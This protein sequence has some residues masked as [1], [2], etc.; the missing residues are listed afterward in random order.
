MTTRF[1]RPVAALASALAVVLAVTMQAQPT[2]AAKPDPFAP[3]KAP[4]MP[5]VEVRKVHTKPAAR[6]AQK[7]AGDRRSPKWPSA[8]SADVTVGDTKA[9]IRF[10]Q[11]SGDGSATANARLAAAK[12]SKMRVDVLDQAASQRAAVDGVLF[13]VRRADGRTGRAEVG[14][15]VDYKAFANAYGADWSTRL[16]LVKLPECALTDPELVRCRG[17]AVPGT[18]DTVA[19]AV[20]ADVAVESAQLMAVTAAPSGAAGSYSA[21]KLSPSGVWSAG[22]S[23]GDFSW[24]FPMRVPP[25][26]GGPSPSV[27]L[28]YSAQSVDGRM[29]ASNNQPSEVGEGFELSTGGFI[30]RRYKPCSADKK[31][32]NNTS[33][34]HKISADMCWVTDNAT[35]SL[36]G[37][38]GELIQDADNE[39]LWHLRN[40]DGS[41]IERRFG[42]DNG[43]HDG[44]WWVVTT[45]TGTQ[46]WFGRNKLPGWSAGDDNTNATWTAPIFSNHS[47]EPCYKPEFSASSCTTPWR[48]NLSYVVDPHGNSMSYWYKADTNNYY[49]LGLGKV[50]TY[51]RGGYLDHVSYG[52]RVLPNLETGTDTIFSGHATARVDFDYGDRCLSDCGTKDAVKWPDT[53][54]DLSC[55]SD[56]E[57]DPLAPTFWSTHRLTT[58]TTSVYEQTTG[59][60]RDVEQWGLTH[61]YPDPE[62]GTRAG[63]WLEKVS[64]T[65]LVGTP[66]KLPDVTFTGYPKPNRI[67]GVDH[68]PAM[69]WHRLTDINTETGSILH[70]DYLDSDCVKGSKVPTVPENNKLRCYPVRWT[71]SGHDDELVDYFAKYVVNSVTE[72]DRTGGSPRVLYQYRY[73]GDP[74]WHYSDDDGLIDKDAKTW[75][76]WRGYQKVGVLTGDPGEQTYRETTYFRGMNGDHLPNGTRSATVPDSQGGSVPDDEAFAGVTRETRTL[77]GV[78]GAEVSGELNEPWKSEPT[79]SRTINKVTT[80]ARR[81]GTAAT[82]TR[83]TLDH[84]PWVRTTT[85]KH[86]FDGYGQVVKTEDLGDAAVPGDEQCVKTTYEPRNTKAW[87]LSMPHRTQTFAV[88]CV[89]ADAGGLTEDQVIGDGRTYYDDQNY[90]VAPKKGDVT[91]VEQMDAYNNGSPSY[92]LVSRSAFDDLGRVTNSWDVLGNETKTAYTPATTG[93]VTQTV[94]TNP[95]GWTTKSFVEPA[96][97]LSTATVDVNQLRTSLEYDG[98]G[99]LTKVWKPG[100]TPGTGTPDIEYSYL[101]RTDGVNAVTT[102]HVNAKGGVTK[103]YT[104]YDGLLRTRQTQTASPSGGR[105]LSDTF[106]D[107]AGRQVLSYGAYYDKTGSPGTELVKPLTQQDVPNQTSVEYDAAGRQIAS[108]FQPKGVE[109]WRT[110]TSYGGDHVDVSPPAGATAS[111]TWTDARGRTIQVRQY[112]TRTPSG[113]D[114]DKTDYKY[115]SKGLLASVTG[116]DGSQWA[117]S[118]DLL[119][120]RTSSIDPDSG[121]TTTKYDT[122]GRVTSTTDGNGQVLISAYDK[123][124]RRVAL[125]KSSV[126]SNNQVAQWDY[127][128][129]TFADGVTPVL[130]QVFQSIRIDS[131]RWYIKG[132]TQYDEN[133]RPKV[134]KVTI[135]TGETGLGGSYT[136]TNGYNADGSLAAMSYPA[137]ADLNAE[138]IKYRYTD[139]DQPLDMTTLY[140]NG[141]ESSIVSDSQ[142]DALA[143]ATQYTLYTGKFSGT[144]SRAYVSLE[145]DATTGRLNKISVH[146]DGKNPNTVTDQKYTYDD[147]GNV[148]KIADKPAGGSFTDIQCFTYDRHRRLQDAWT[149]ASDDCI[150]APTN[151]TLGGPAP[152]WQSYSYNAA[153]ARTGLVDHATA[154]GD[155]STTY[156]FADTT[157]AVPTTGQPHVLRSTSTVDSTGTRSATYTYDKAGNTKT[158]PGPNGTQTL[159]WDAENRLQSVTDTSGSNSYLYDADG[160]RLISRDKNGR[161]LYLP[162]QEVRYNNSSATQSCTRYYSFAGSTLAQRTSKGLTW[163]ASDHHGTQ[164]VSIDSVT[165]TETVRRQTP[166]GASRGPNVTWANTKGFVGGTEDPTGLIHIGA[167]EYD[168]ALGRFISVDPVMDS[169][170]PQ[171]MNGYAYA[172]NN[173][174]VNADPSG[175]MY[176][177]ES[178]GGSTVTETPPSTSSTQEEEPPSQPSGQAQAAPQTQSPPKKEPCGWLCKAGNWVDDHKAE[179]A[180][181]AA[182][183]VVGIGCGMAIG[184]TGVGAVAC[185]AAAG[186]VAGAVEYSVNTAVEHEGNWSLGG[187]TKAAVGGAIVG[188]VTGGLFSVGGAGIKA[189]VS[190]MLSGTGAKAAVNAG[191]SAAKKEAGNIVSGLT[192]GGFRNSASKA[193]AGAADG[194]PAAGKRNYAKDKG[195]LRPLTGPYR[196]DGQKV[197]HGH[198]GWDSADGY[199]TVPEGTSVAFYSGHGTEINRFKTLMVGG[200]TRMGPVDVKGP[201][202]RIP[203]YALYPLEVGDSYREGMTLVFE[204]TLLSNLL[205]E[206][207]GTVHW[208]ACRSVSG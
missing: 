159:V 151:A 62:D 49:S 174:I 141:I 41:R 81:T 189:G 79:A 112:P 127:D 192:R 88:D 9:P 27:E 166:F 119:G 183:A 21:T 153:G 60:F 80:H 25:G 56:T 24:S 208:A 32:G 205:E 65:G 176:P 51:T 38:G 26:I 87:I 137:T 194:M 158:R 104:L 17:I 67:D 54:W 196:P 149:P 76:Q 44:E 199:I 96:W 132:V 117:Y 202:S 136:Y 169:S 101:I 142:Y 8:A 64:H 154:K 30:E 114:Y 14:V 160:N 90:G 92:A 95:L 170:N 39:N 2:W 207:Q 146:R 140:G 52:T 13:R 103:S 179:I 143:H 105:I 201:G 71:P 16:Q 73:I 134:S 204:R 63:L 18:N 5:A 70:V 182:G 47:G 35:M 29:V 74:A 173:P 72:T 188:G 57:C 53:P 116:P 171:S 165:Q 40:D 89:K 94:D 55:T 1:S 177:M 91:K 195:Q 83:T 185:G 23:S 108:V 168:S 85:T 77:L 75:N 131:G 123:L 124:S 102:S 45:T 178:G 135:P 33:D 191:T 133:Y 200:D 110:T 99:R 20:S 180:G 46:Y 19:Q 37:A 34:L 128:Q 10:R 3:P 164:N 43:T 198:G 138:T 167:R 98:L 4:E 172:G 120:R 111:S 86:H 22:G 6:A 115:N 203:N 78:G 50:R 126:T 187:M 12:P 93:P 193:S 129:A 42:A 118:Y 11:A 36:G 106:Y 113:D 122:A 109:R 144:G 121:T 84:A 190:S 184:W 186:A 82:H 145:T 48:W 97:G 206:G 28:K 147:V 148:T 130:G 152:Y 155:V 162:G 15:T 58:I 157:P 156:R 100:S 66:T 181:A 150:A 163:L 175:L 31:D 59:K 68:S 61:S 69:N 197:L 7:Q 107:S 139:H 125:Y 161:T